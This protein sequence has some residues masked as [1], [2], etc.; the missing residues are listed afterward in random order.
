MMLH[1]INNSYSQK[2]KEIENLAQ[3]LPSVS[4]MEVCGTHTTA[5]GRSG[6]RQLL[7]DNI[8]LISG[9][10]CPVCVTHKREIDNYLELAKEKRVI[11]ATFGDLLQVP[12]SESTLAAAK[13]RGANVVVVYSTLDALKLARDNPGHGIVFLGIGFETTAPTVALSIIQAK[14][15]GLKNYSVYSMHKLVPPVLKALLLDS[16]VKLDGFICPGH[17]S[18]IIGTAPY[19]FIARD[20]NKPCVI[21]GFEIHDILD[22]LYLLL[23]QI[24]QQ[25]AEVRIQYTKGVQPKGSAI[26]REVMDIVFRSGSVLWRGFGMISD[27]GLYI[28][29][30]FKDY[31]ATVKFDFAVDHYSKDEEEDPCSC[32]DILKGLRAPNEC[33]LFKNPCTPRNPIG[34]CMVSSEGA[35]GAYYR[36]E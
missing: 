29:E 6:L 31:D 25:R 34:P 36:Y 4:I 9:P 1:S 22:G 26:A 20:Y 19:N 21:T 15:Q 32:G 30:K 23:L 27:S 13:S 17:V 33:S 24:T 16:S 5:I 14:S 11:I 3:R 10:G 7:P 35:C 28:K 12:G 2:L 8:K 18:T